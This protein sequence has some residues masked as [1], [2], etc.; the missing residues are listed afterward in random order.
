MCLVWVFL[1]VKA[2]GKRMMER[3]V[4]QER[5]R[6]SSMRLRFFGEGF[7]KKW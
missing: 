7:R 5:E 6:L 1:E 4:C 3:V 2:R